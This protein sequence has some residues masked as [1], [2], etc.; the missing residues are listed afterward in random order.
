MLLKQKYD[1]KFDEFIFIMSQVK[2]VIL[3]LR[4]KLFTM[5]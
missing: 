4:L 1:T 5:I 2:K 3:Y